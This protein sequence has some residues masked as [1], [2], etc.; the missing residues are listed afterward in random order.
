[1]WKTVTVAV[2]MEN[3]SVM[4]QDQLVIQVL[5]PEVSW[6][7]VSSVQYWVNRW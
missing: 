5:S 3:K 1:M 6:S 4:G 2:Q 7:A